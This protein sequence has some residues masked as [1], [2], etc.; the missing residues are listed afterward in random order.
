MVC[1]GFEP[2]A[3]GWLVQTKPHSYGGPPC[4]FSPEL[5]NIYIFVAFVWTGN[6]TQGDNVYKWL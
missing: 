2:A 1:L 6:Q 4:L 3:A 5:I